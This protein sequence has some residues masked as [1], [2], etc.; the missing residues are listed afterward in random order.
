MHSG[1]VRSSKFKTQS[2]FIVAKQHFWWR[3]RK[4]QLLELLR[5]INWPFCCFNPPR[6]KLKHEFL[7]PTRKRHCSQAQRGGNYL[8]EKS[9]GQ[10]WLQGESNCS[11]AHERK[12]NCPLAHKRN[13]SVGQRE[14]KH[15]LNGFW[16]LTLS[17]PFCPL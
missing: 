13:C 11:V 8:L 16:K 5:I 14:S 17:L 2:E 12:R 1:S 10:Y 6:A 3:Q 7:W 4:F 15:G 9:K